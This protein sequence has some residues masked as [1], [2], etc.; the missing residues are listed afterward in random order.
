VIVGACAVGIAGGL[1]TL[2]RARPRP[3]SYGQAPPLGDA[4]WVQIAPDGNVTVRVNVA[5]MGQGAVTGLLQALADELDVEWDRLQFE[6]APVVDDFAGP[7][8][9]Y[10]G[11][12][13]S[14][15]THLQP[16]R[17]LGASARA[18][19]IAAAAAQWQAS[20]DECLAESGRVIHRPSGRTLPY[21]ELAASAASLPVPA[22]VALKTPA[23][24][25]YIGKSV[26][27]PGIATL[28][29]GTARFGIDMDLPDLHIAT[30][31]HCPVHGGTLASVDTAPALAIDGVTQVV[32]LAD[33][34]AVIARGY[35]QA[36]KGAA[37]LEPH[38]D[39]DPALQQSDADLDELL[40]TMLQAAAGEVPTTTT[41]P[42]R[43][44]QATYQVPPLAQAPL[45]PMN[46]TARVRD[47]KVEVWAPTQAGTQARD[48]IANALAVPP[49]S[50][51]VYPTLIGGG[52]GRRLHN[53]YAIEAAL[54]ASKTGVPVKVISS[55]EEDFLHT[56]LR[57]AFRARMQATLDDTG[58]PRSLTALVAGLTPSQQMAGLDSVP[59][60][61]ATQQQAYRGASSALRAGYWRSVAHSQ[62]IFFLESFIDECAHAAGRDPL[63]YRLAMLPEASAMA[64]V[65]RELARQC[66]YPG[67]LQEGRTPGLACSEGFGSHVAV[68]ITLQTTNPL[69]IA[70]IWCVIDCGFA[71]NPKGVELQVEGGLL[72]ALSAALGE[73]IS[74][75]NGQVEQKNYDSYQV[76]RMAGVPRVHVQII[77]AKA[78]PHGGVGEAAVPPVAPAL[79]N[80]M[81]RAGLPRSR[82]L[83]LDTHRTRADSARHG[84]HPRLSQA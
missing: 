60:Q 15:R 37:A 10:T 29:D 32:R 4:G 1:W 40:Q 27:R 19:L 8:G 17:E 67:R 49:Q 53:D 50:V 75:R 77:S 71:I 51:T 66:N 64:N 44:V 23:Q 63:E 39:I 16:Y 28:V 14:L 18:M 25:R 36:H 79:A 70:D 31:R 68:A 42:S 72:F 69:A 38:W 5:E 21:G 3:P 7:N 76:L 55:R 52:F 11:G 43:T 57:P 74:F 6:L 65:L 82:V 58:L 78:R 2:H 81:V 59:Y 80:A 22:N 26:Q 48:L 33:S 46:A 35:W 20:V 61:I 47:G 41:A 30:V 9:H 83:P 34:V 54:I 73:R 45:E 13:R 24:W 62:N 56:T 12:S 84:A